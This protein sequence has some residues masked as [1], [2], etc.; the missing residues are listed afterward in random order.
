MVCK[1]Y[2]N[3]C[4]LSLSKTFCAFSEDFILT[5]PFCSETCGLPF[6]EECHRWL[7]S[8]VRLNALVDGV[9]LTS[10]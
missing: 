9:G 8:A 7:F 5:A 10:I 6:L 3:Q 2:L 4:S 1:I